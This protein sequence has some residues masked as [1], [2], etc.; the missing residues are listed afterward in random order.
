MCCVGEGPPGVPLEV[1]LTWRCWCFW[2]HL[3]VWG[4]AEDLVGDAP[5]T[6]ATSAAGSIHSPCAWQ[7]LVWIEGLW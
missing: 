1:P 5:V 6:S 7:R 3:R 2:D 4:E